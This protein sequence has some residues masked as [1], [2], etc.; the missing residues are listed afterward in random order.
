[1]FLLIASVVFAEDAMEKRVEVKMD[2]DGVQRVEVI[3]GE[4]YFDPN[5]IIVKVNVP[6]EL[7][8]RKTG[9]MTPHTIV[10]KAPEAGIDVDETLASEPKS[11]N[12]TPTKTGKYAFECTKRLL[13][14]KS[15]KDRGM[16]GSLEVVD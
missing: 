4:Y 16:H 7:R 13:F 6:V 12:F 14:F 2:A 8:I 10:L 15:H 1:M 5:V 9:G 3:G 11:V